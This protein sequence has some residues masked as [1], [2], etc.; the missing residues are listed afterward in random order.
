M[1]KINLRQYL[2]KKYGNKAFMKN[3]KI[4]VIYLNMALKELNKNKT[5]YYHA[6]K[7]HFKKALIE[8][9]N[10]KKGYRK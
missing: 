2:L 9:K 3:G 10:F 1:V 8:A 4:K 5:R 6:T 7:E